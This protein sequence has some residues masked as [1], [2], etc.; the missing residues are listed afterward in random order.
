M[1]LGTKMPCGN[2][3]SMAQI[4]FATWEPFFNDD[5]RKLKKYTGHCKRGEN[6]EI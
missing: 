4:R 3:N 2:T 5:F 6:P 1:K